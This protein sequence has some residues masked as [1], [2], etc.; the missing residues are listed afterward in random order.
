MVPES[1]SEFCSGAELLGG[2]LYMVLLDHRDVLQLVHCRCNRLL[3]IVPSFNLV[4][5]TYIHEKI[6]RIQ[7]IST[8][9]WEV[10]AKT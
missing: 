9:G 5:R 6:S 2:A 8:K 10:F 7:G 3:D 1:T 4:H